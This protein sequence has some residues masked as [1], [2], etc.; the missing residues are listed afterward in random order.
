MQIIFDN[1]KDVITVPESKIT[2]TEITVNELFDSPSR[3]V[4]YATT[5]ELGLIILWS[6]NE[7]DAIGQWTD[8][9]VID[10]IKELYQ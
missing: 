7:Y 5:Q 2:L 3:K 10:R 6:G 8:Q 9:N 4:V 1:P